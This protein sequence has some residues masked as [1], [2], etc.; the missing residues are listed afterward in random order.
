M[1]LKN[2]EVNE[3]IRLEKVTINDIEVIIINRKDL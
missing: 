2:K 1:K 3:N